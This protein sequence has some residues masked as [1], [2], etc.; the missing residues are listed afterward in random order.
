MAIFSK[1][2]RYQN[3]GLLIMRLGIGAM[4]I[5][6]G[7]PKLKG[8]PDLWE[9][10]GQAMA[11]FGVHDFPQFWG[12]MAGFTEAVGGLLFLIGFLFRPTCIFLLFVM[13]VAAMQSY[14]MGGMGNAAQ[15]IELGFVFLAMFII[16]PGSIS[17][18]KR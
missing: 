13:I 6:H 14:T 8:G 17:I 9:K 1:L 11:Q 10:V 2:A 3:F 5:W 16:G 18:D 7:F 4:M 12:F 15:P